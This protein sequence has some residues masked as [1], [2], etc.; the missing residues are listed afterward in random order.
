MSPEG[1]RTR[2]LT[3]GFEAG[4]PKKQAAEDWLK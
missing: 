1:Q 3:I 4:E 2:S